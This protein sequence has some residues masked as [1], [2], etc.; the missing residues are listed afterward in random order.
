MPRN[1]P[2]TDEENVLAALGAAKAQ[3]AKALLIEIG[4]NRILSITV[5]LDDEY[6]RLLRDEEAVHYEVDLKTG[7]KKPN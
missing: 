2:A 5:F 4:S 6:R 7:L 1:R 3:G